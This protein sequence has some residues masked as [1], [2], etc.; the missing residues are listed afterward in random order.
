MHRGEPHIAMTM[1]KQD[2]DIKD[3]H[4]VAEVL[5]VPN[6]GNSELEEKALVRKIDAFLLPTIWLM[7]LLS[8]VDR[9]KSAPPSYEIARSSYFV[10]ALVMRRSLVCKAIFI[11]RQVNTPLH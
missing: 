10:V 9:T 4:G 6:A 3:I 2:Q 1:E 8:Y 5:E 7:Y 11:S